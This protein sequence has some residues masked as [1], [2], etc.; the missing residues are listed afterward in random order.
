MASFVGE[1]NAFAGTVIKAD[2]SGA[3]V[4][5]AF[6]RLRG[7]NP[8]GLKSGDKAIIFVRPESLKPG[9]RAADTT[10]ASEVNSVAFEGNVTHVYLKGAGQEGHHPH[11]RTPWRRKDSGARRQDRYRLRRGHGHRAA[12]REDG[13]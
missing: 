5:T 13:P 9:K 4:E 1:N 6:G 8:K 11:R 10:L 12:G 2:K 7:R 3:V